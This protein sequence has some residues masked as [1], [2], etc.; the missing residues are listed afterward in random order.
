MLGT[1]RRRVARGAKSLRP[2]RW[3]PG[4]GLP[5]WTF[6]RHCHPAPMRHESVP[7]CPLGGEVF[8][9][10][11]GPRPSTVG[12]CMSMPCPSSSSGRSR[13]GATAG[14][15]LS[16]DHSIPSPISGPFSAQ[17]TVPKSIGCL[18]VRATLRPPPPP[19]PPPS[20]FPCLCSSLSASCHL[21]PP[22]PQWSGDSL[23]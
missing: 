15:A 9:H 3:L 8:R 18:A 12:M 20:F 22:L 4:D 13:R 14:D 10:A 23:C 17:A 1:L 2:R 16:S 19:P 7:G 6:C 21:R 5:L 11:A